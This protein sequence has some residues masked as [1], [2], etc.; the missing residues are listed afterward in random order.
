VVGSA[1]GTWRIFVVIAYPAATEGFST[2]MEMSMQVLFIGRYIARGRNCS[3]RTSTVGDNRHRESPVLADLKSDASCQN[4]VRQFP[5]GAIRIDELFG[6][7]LTGAPPQP[8]FD[9]LPEDGR[10]V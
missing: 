7:K 9:D 10:G 2:D 3:I 5:P 6:R 4:G 1:P 8:V